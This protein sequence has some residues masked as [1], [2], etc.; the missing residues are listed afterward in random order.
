MSCEEVFDLKSII[1][2][3]LAVTFL[4]VLSQGL[5][6]SAVTVTWTD[7]A[8]PQSVDLIPVNINPADP[9]YIFTDQAWYCHLFIHM[10][11]M[12]P[13]TFSF[14]G[15]YTQEDMVAY[16]Y[17]LMHET[18]YNE[19]TVNWTDFHIETSPMD[20]MDWDEF[21]WASGLTTPW[22]IDQQLEYVYFTMPVDGQP[23]RPGEIFYDGVFI[24]DDFDEVADLTIVKYPTPIPEV[25]SAVVLLSGLAG[26]LGY[27]KRRKS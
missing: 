15:D 18:V 13:I 6:W 16:P 1:C 22:D 26:M 17:I 20:P 14:T 8:G 11:T 4:F 12:S 25:G 10:N 9:Y 2:R 27:I 19:T 24:F 5:A 7:A 21:G 23:V 3:A